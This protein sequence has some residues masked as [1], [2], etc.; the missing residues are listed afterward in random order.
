MTPYMANGGGDCSSP[1]WPMTIR[2]TFYTQHGLDTS[3]EEMYL[4]RKAKYMENALVSTPKTK[5]IVYD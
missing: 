4:G 5:N 3:N 1:F 2:A